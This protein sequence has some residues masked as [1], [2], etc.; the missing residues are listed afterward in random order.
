MSQTNQ[1]AQTL[2]MN[3]SVGIGYL[4][5]FL[6]LYA[7]S[8]TGSAAVLSDAAESVVHVVAISFARFSLYLS[9]KKASE[10]FSY[11]FDRIS[12]FSAGVEGTLI[13][14]AAVFILYESVQ[15][16]LLQRR[17]EELGLGTLLTALVV[18]VNGL[19]GLYLIRVGKRTQSLILEA[20]GKHVLSDSITSIG[21]VLGLVMVLLTDQFWFDPLIGALAGINIFVEGF[22]LMRRSILGL[23]D[24]VD[25]QVLNKVKNEVADFARANQIKFHDL[26]CRNSGTRLW[27]QV[28]LL[29]D[30]HVLLRDAH[31][32][33]TAL[34]K[35][36]QQLWQGSQIITHLEIKGDHQ[37][38]HCDAHALD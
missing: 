21:A 31:F 14:L 36:I 3:L 9:R 25:P 5:L 7:Y 37:K 32:M 38:I 22:K 18:V 16:F 23:M 6:K 8:I 19:L 10:R 26:R 2:A 30:D 35:H 12:F 28:H 11:G 29:Y 1:S 17:P 34:E 15:S 13:F 27:I 24:E 4:L 33:A 20:D